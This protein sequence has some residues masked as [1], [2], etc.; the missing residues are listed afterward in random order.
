MW[1]SS[2]SAPI[3]TARTAGAPTAAA[4]DWIGFNLDKGLGIFTFGGLTLTRSASYAETYALYLPV[5]V[6][7][8]CRFNLLGL[9]AADP[10]KVPAGATN[11]PAAALQHYRD[12]LAAGPAVVAGDFNR[13]PQQM[14]VRAQWSRQLGGRCAGGGRPDQRR[15]RHERRLGPAG[16]ATDALPSAQVFARLRG[17]LHLHSSRRDRPT[18]R[19]RGGRS[20][21]LDHLERSRA[22]GRRVRFVLLGARSLLTSGKIASMWYD[23]CLALLLDNLRGDPSGFERSPIELRILC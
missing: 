9:W 2:R 4:Y 21:R 16:A 11:D 15:L 22:V 18:Q 5:V 14:S 19:V 13:L 12:F 1:R 17:R 10:R 7:G 6:A 8:W 23:M 3:P 20:P